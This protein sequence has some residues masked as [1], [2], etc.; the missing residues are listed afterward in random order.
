VSNDDDD[1][2]LLGQLW[3]FLRRLLLVDERR[4][5]C[6]ATPLEAMGARTGLDFLRYHMMTIIVYKMIQLYH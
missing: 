5:R 1:D 6:Y 3:D 2:C 4:A